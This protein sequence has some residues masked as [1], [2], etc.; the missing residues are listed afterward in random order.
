VSF[1]ILFSMVRVVIESYQFQAF[2]RSFPSTFSL[3]SSVYSTRNFINSIAQ[4]KIKLSSLFFMLNSFIQAALKLSILWEVML[5][6]IWF[7]AP[8]LKAFF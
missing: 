4:N 6:T 5:P 7:S 1:C 8:I 2:N 3:V